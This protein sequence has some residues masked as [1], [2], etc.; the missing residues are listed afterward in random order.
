MSV[1]TIR[2]INMS[3]SQSILLIGKILDVIIDLIF[4]E[5]TSTQ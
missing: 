5:E 3:Y 1:E 4:S 2:V